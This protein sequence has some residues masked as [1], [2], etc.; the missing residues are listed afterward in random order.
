MVN[1]KIKNIEIKDNDIFE[2]QLSIL[3]PLIIKNTDSNKYDTN[4][5][6]AK[7]GRYFPYCNYLN[8]NDILCY[9]F[10]Y[11]YKKATSNILLII[12]SLTKYEYDSKIFTKSKLF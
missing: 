8:H 9:G 4:Y 3:K 11:N 5:H 6:L 2:K 1:Q 10:N 7:G 12:F